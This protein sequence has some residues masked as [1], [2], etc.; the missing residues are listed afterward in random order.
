MGQKTEIRH[1]IFIHDKMSYFG[2]YV[3]YLSIIDNN[4]MESLGEA[5]LLNIY[6]IIHLMLC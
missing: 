2:F 1:L 4:F 3:N 6:E 5:A